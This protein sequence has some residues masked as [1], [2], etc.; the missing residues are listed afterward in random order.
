MTRLFFS[1]FVVSLL[2]IF[3][4][5]CGGGGT[6]VKGKVTFDDGTPLTVGTVI[7]ETEMLEMIGMIQKDGTYRMSTDGKTPG[8]PKGE[9][10]VAIVGAGESIGE[11][12]PVTF[13][14]IVR[15][16]IDGK[17]R[18]SSLSGLTC[19]VDGATTFNITVTRP[20][21]EFTKRGIPG[22]PPAPQR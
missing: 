21:E 11:Y 7:F 22:L 1:L 13:N 20:T 5:G 19:K 4:T 10:K 14:L 6:S 2:C 9:Y 16:L 8:I 3:A 17:F 15:P 18:D 12:D